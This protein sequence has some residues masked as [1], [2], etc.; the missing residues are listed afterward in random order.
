MKLLFTSLFSIIAMFPFPPAPC[1][2]HQE[3]TA[4]VS[5]GS[6]P[7]I[8]AK[9]IRVKTNRNIE[10]FGL[11]MQLDMGPDLATSKDSVT[12][13]NRKSTWREWYAMTYKNYLRY[14]KFDSC[15]MMQRYRELVGKKYYNDFFIGFLLQ[16]DEV[17]FAKINAG[18]DKETLLAFS[19]TGD[20]GEATK[21]ATAFLQEF[22]KF[23][24]LLH[25]G[26]YLEENN[27][28]YELIQSDVR[29]NLP[30]SFFI[31]V[32]EGFYGKS[33]NAYYLIPSLNI[34]T[35]Q[36]FGKMNKTSRTIYNTFGP[37]SFQ[38]FDKRHPELGF[39]YPEKI[40]RLSVHEFGHSFVNPAIDK[41]P[42]ELKSSTEYLYQPIKEDMSKSAYTNWTMCLYEHFVKAGEV[43][44]ARK[45]GHPA[46]AD[47]MLQDCVRA[48]FIYVPFIVKELE[49][50]DAGTDP[51]KNYDDF[52]K[53]VLEDLKEANKS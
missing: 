20:Y 2:Y 41:L 33:F 53:T 4:S 30:D 19:P 9:K 28:F 47:K 16:V 43:I 5:R 21:N 37:F 18:T 7:C 14:K 35:S 27:R 6:S 44:V 13:E 38:T 49:R 22:N 51:G 42:D 23:Y 52:I 46:E 1:V 32:M 39:D 34:P 15:A 3:R 48:R 31:P 24:A 40:A 36:G 25:F 12:I 17:P 11:M 50:Y 26:S 45:L 10:L 29:R 8:L